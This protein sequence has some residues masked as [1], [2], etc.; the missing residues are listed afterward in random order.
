LGLWTPAAPDRPEA[1]PPDEPGGDGRSRGWWRCAAPRGRRRRRV[2]SS[3]CAV[4]APERLEREVLRHSGLANDSED[5]AI[6]LR[7]KPPEQRLEGFGVSL[8]EALQQFHAAFLLGL[9]GVRTICYKKSWCH[10]AASSEREPLPTA[11]LRDASKRRQDRR[12]I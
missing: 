9:T 12:T 1:P 4:D 7:L 8:P 6:H 10:A 2:E 5:P 3:S 11:T